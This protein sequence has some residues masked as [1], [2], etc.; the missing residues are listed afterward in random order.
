[1][2]MDDA[3]NSL[4]LSLWCKHAPL[5]YQW[6]HDERYDRWFRFAIPAVFARLNNLILENRFLKEDL[7]TVVKERDELKRRVE[8]LDHVRNRIGG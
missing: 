3:E 4:L 2:D 5:Q 6:P 8:E 1:M 7:A